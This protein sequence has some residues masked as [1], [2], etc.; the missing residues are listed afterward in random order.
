MPNFQIFSAT[1][2]PIVQKS[3]QNQQKSTQ[4]PGNFMIF[5]TTTK[6]STTQTN[7]Q[8]TSLNNHLVSTI[9]A[10]SL[11]P[12]GALTPI[13]SDTNFRQIPSKIPSS[14][15][16]QPNSLF[17]SITQRPF[18]TNL[19]QQLNVDKNQLHVFSRPSVP[20]RGKQAKC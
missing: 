7:N 1:M 13:N 18:Q 17:P 5:P 4:N 14:G 10:N 19:D 3:P 9:S 15:V 20:E 8:A 11:F 6:S 16:N 12:D 2:Q